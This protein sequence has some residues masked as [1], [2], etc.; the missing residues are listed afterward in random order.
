DVEIKT[1]CAS[2]E[3]LP[4]LEDARFDIV[5]HP[6]STC[7]VPDLAPVYEEVSRLLRDDGIYIGQHKQP[8]NL[9]I[10]AATARGE[11]ALGIE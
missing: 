9:Q 7:Y 4:M 6:V 2:M 5:H 8:T 1:V 10:A 3:N 11:Y